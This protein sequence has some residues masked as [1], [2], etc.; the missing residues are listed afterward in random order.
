[1]KSAKLLDLYSDFFTSSPNIVSAL[2]SSK[3]LGGTYSHDSITRMLAQKEI[4]QQDYWK[5][6][7]PTVRRIESDD[8]AITIDDTIEHTPYS[9]ENEIVAWH[10]DHTSGTSVKGINILTFTY[11]NT[12]IEPTIKLPVA[13]EI[14]RK[15]LITKDKTGKEIRQSSVNKNELLRQ[16]L[17]VLVHHN[18]I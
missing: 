17:K 15:D 11:V 14:I 10:Y 12:E 7:K 9:D 4:S 8:G 1:M 5:P 16:R 2:V 6:V 3:V 13:F 18:H